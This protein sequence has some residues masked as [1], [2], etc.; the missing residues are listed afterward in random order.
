M[1][2]VDAGR[3]REAGHDFYRSDNGVWLVDEVPPEFICF[4]ESGSEP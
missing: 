3:M 4:P 1:L 2:T